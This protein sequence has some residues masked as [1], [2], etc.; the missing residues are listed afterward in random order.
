VADYVR[1]W[2]DKGEASAVVLYDVGSLALVTKYSSVEVDD[3][4]RLRTFTEKPAD[5]TSTLVAT[6]S[7]VYHREHVALIRRYLDEGNAPDQPGRLLGW[8]VPRVPV[9]G[10]RAGGDWRDIGDAAQ[11]LEADNRLRE[12]AGLPSRDSYALD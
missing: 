6:A 11:L 7:Y 9:Y 10:Y 8:L 2:Q 5:P 1:W 4:G 3:D 12:L